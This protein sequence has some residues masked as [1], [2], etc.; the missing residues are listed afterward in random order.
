[1]PATAHSADFPIAPGTTELHW[2]EAPHREGNV[3]A[4]YDCL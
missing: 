2:N 1:L 3:T 4:I